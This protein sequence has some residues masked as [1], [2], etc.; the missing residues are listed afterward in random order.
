[1]VELRPSPFKP[2]KGI[3]SSQQ[4]FYHLYKDGK[5]VDRTLYTKYGYTGDKN[6][7]IL[8]LNKRTIAEISP[9]IL[10]SCRKSC[11]K[12]PRYTM[13]EDIVVVSGETGKIIF[14]TNDSYCF[15]GTPYIISDY[16]FRYKDTLYNNKGEVIKA[17]TKI[18]DLHILEDTFVILEGHSYRYDACY[19]FDKS[20]E[21]LNT[22]I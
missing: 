8:V 16:V 2:G 14:D 1:M 5:I 17:F 6:K 3:S 13:A 11:G 21:L 15:D 9:S 12:Y 22:Y 19:V 20:G 10:D 4:Q 18:G 7:N